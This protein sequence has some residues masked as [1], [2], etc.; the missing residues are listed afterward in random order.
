MTE[1]H[2]HP[3]D[4]EFNE[5][6]PRFQV[7]VLAM[8]VETLGREKEKIEEDLDEERRERRL[9]DKRVASME[10]TFQRGA[11]VALALPILGAALGL[12]LAYGR[13]IFAPWINPR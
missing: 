2:D 3:L 10:R 5:N 13:V 11:G 12:L 8:R 7:R 6:D 1:H 9:L 4:G